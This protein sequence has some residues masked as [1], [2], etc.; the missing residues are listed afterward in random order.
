MER[1]CHICRDGQGTPC[2]DTICQLKVRWRWGG[3][4]TAGT[5]KEGHRALGHSGGFLWLCVRAGL[6]PG[7]VSGQV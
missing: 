1:D 7:S 3:G 4:M 5:G 2:L 6:T